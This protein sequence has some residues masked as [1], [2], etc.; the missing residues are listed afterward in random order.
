M[1]S[2]IFEAS[3]LGTARFDACTNLDAPNAMVTLRTQWVDRT[4]IQNY[5]TRLLAEIAELWAPMK[6]AIRMQVYGDQVSESCYMIILDQVDHTQFSER[7]LSTYRSVLSTH[8]TQCPQPPIT[9]DV[10]F[11]P[12]GHTI[13]YQGRE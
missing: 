3:G 1:T 9:H 7:A 4:D 6:P 13:Q 8:R 12:S 11:L 5:A 2:M 10:C